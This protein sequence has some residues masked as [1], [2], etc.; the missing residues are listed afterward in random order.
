MISIRTSLRGGIRW[1]E[2]A[3]SERCHC[4]LLLPGIQEASPMPLGGEQVFGFGSWPLLS[5]QGSHT[6]RKRVI[7]LAGKFLITWSRSPAPPL[8]TG[9]NKHHGRSH[10]IPSQPSEKPKLISKSLCFNHVHR[11]PGQHRGISLKLTYLPWKIHLI[12][13]SGG[14]AG[15]Y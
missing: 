7:V 9:W 10:T 5:C 6:V 3:D 2:T 4:H 11:R 1:D 8:S 12:P 13:F 15:R 14:G